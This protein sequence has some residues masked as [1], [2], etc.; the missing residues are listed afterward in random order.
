MKPIHVST[1]SPKTLFG[2]RK[3]LKLRSQAIISESKTS[4][5]TTAIKG[6]EAINPASGDNHFHR[7]INDQD[8]II[9]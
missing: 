1:I 9:H 2:G 7:P 4:K 3:M 6:L 5:K 8:E